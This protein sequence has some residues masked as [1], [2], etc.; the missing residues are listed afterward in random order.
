[1]KQDRSS[2]GVMLMIVTMLIFAAQD[3]ISR[4]LAET[5]NTI[6][7]V[8]IRYWFFAIFVVV[9]SMVRSGGIRRVAR[10]KRPV[11][12]IVRS[13][14]LVAEILVMV[15][16]FIRLGL[17]GSHA[18]FACFPLIVTALSVPM[19][20]ERVGWRRWSAVGLGFVGVMIILRP[21]FQVFSVDALIPV[22]AALMFANYHIL[23]RL[24]SRVDSPETSFFWTG[25]AGAVAISMIGPFFWDPMIGG[26]WIWMAV[27]CVISALGHFL[28]IQALTFAEASTI[29]PYSYFQL[30]FASL[31]GIL[32]F[33]DTLDGWTITGGVVIAASGLFAMLRQK[34]LTKG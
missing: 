3:G 15:T 22:L 5:Y 33:G 18:I 2:L 13:V 6:T 25:V 9:L 27:L 32:V 34:D 23:T 4:H 29:Q 26:D 14:L 16:G 12:Q 28:L 20:G 30:V 31:A 7:V 21:G 11:L 19:L 10:T 17:V 8:M 24:A 1:M